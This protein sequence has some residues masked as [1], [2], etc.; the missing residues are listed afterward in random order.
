MNKLLSSIVLLCAL[1]STTYADQDQDAC[2]A[3]FNN[4]CMAKCQETDDINCPAA[5]QNQAVNQCQDAGQ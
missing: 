3:E 2:V 1:T 5:C 4:Q